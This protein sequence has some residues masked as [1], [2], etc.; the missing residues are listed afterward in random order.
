MEKTGY[1]ARRVEYFLKITCT[2]RAWDFGLKYHRTRVLII[3][4]TQSS[5]SVSQIT[6]VYLNLYSVLI[7]DRVPDTKCY[8][9][10]FV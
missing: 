8:P 10:Y 4:L 2:A 1:V 3:L 6:D 5:F 9:Y 7:F